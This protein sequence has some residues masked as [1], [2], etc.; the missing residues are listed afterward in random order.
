MNSETRVLYLSANVK[1]A[2][3]SVLHNSIKREYSTSCDYS[4]KETK[5]GLSQ[6]D[7]SKGQ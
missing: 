5:T 7:R 1:A 6:A 3:G 2:T 4:R